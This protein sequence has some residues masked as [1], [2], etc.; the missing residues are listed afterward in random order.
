MHGFS[1]QLPE[2][3]VMVRRMITESFGIEKYIEEHINSTNYLFRMKYS[4]L[5]KKEKNDGSIHHLLIMMIVMMKRQ[6]EVY[7]LIPIRTPSQQF[8][9]I[10][11]M[12]W[13]LKQKTKNGSKGHHLI[14][15]SSSRMEILC[16]QVL[17][18]SNILCLYKINI[19]FQAY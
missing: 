6:S 7:L 18:L 2:L 4:L 9:S 3:D 5:I 19:V 15:L 13:K 12:V 11:L 8:I 10:K 14:I 1:K 17:Q 16:V